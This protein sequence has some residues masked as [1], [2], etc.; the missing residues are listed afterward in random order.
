MDKVSSCELIKIESVFLF[1]NK[2]VKIS[3]LIDNKMYFF[4]IL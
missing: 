3:D 2:E 1:V 4:G